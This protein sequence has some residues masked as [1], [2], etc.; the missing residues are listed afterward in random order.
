MNIKGIF[1]IA[2]TDRFLPTSS[3]GAGSQYLN[4]DGTTF[5]VLLPMC[6]GDVANLAG[7]RVFDRT[8]AFTGNNI[9]IPADNPARQKSTYSVWGANHNFFNM[10]WQQSESAGC[11]GPNNNP[12]FPIPV[13]DGSG[14]P[15]QRTTG[16]A[17]VLAFFRANVGTSP[18]TSFNQ[19][20]NPR[21][22]LP[23]LITNIPER[24]DRGFTSSPSSTFTKV[25]FDFPANL[26]D[27][28]GYVYT[29][30]EVV[31]TN[32]TAI[33]E[34]DYATNPTP[35][36]AGANP[37]PCP[38]PSPIGLVMTVGSITWESASCSNYFQATWT[39]S[40]ESIAAYQTLDFRVSR[41]ID[42]VR[43]TSGSTNFQI[44]FI[45]ANGSPTGVALSL[46]KYLDLTGPVGLDDGTP[47]G[48]LHP[49]LQTVRIPLSDFIG[50][51][52]SNVRG[53]RFVF[54]DTPK[55][56]I[57]LANIR[58]SNQP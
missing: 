26:P 54:S 49:I 19:N 58:L 3:G 57:Y 51:N 24:I 44:Q 46:N 48:F 56:A 55:G 35:C 11:R 27:N 14:S 18:D 13:T 2:P 30:P 34:H 29:Y 10:E 22:Q 40:G 38:T 36:Y 25:L 42:Y 39:I 52:L 1:E 31:F 15:N 12:L 45:A 41:Q 28:S 47:S 43:N 6:D 20:F 4:A 21:Y 37:P 50:A 7:V 16:S 53:V 5:N 17:S 8:M 9:G 33:P 32:A 23:G